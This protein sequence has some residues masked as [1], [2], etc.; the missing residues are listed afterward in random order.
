ML[1]EQNVE[2]MGG[3]I[4]AASPIT[5]QSWCK[6]VPN[7]PIMTYGHSWPQRQSVCLK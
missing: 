3:E 7:E 6:R 4:F 2:E 1:L 5:L